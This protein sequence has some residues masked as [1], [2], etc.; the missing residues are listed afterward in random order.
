MST[1]ATQLNW[2]SSY[3]VEDFYRRF[4]HRNASEKHYV[5]ASQLATVLLV[6][7]PLRFP[8]N[9]SIRPAGKLFS[10]SA[11]APA[12]S[13][14][15][16]GIGGASMPGAKF[17]AMATAM[18]VTLALNWHGLWQRLLG[19]SEPFTGSA[20]VLFAKTALT[21]TLVT[22]VVWII[23]TLFT[24]KEPDE[25][26]VSFYRKVR[27][28]ITGWR[29][30]AALAPE[31]VPTRDLPRNLWCWILGCIMTYSALFGVGKLLL[32]EWLPGLILSFVAIATATQMWRELHR[33]Q[34]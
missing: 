11:P 9:C 17:P 22:T 4:V 7:S 15:C 34:E 13:I 1:I 28:Q 32:R 27:P 33:F 23:V 29:P 6:S 2:G 26:L 20:T 12:A 24:S 5:N 3:L 21:T 30:I 19:R 14:C 16:A 10:N 25:I 8:C 31:I 18:A